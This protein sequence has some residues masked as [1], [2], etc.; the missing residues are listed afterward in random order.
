M[1]VDNLKRR[2]WAEI[3]LDNAK[4]NYNQIKSHIKCKLCCVVKANAYGHGAIKLAKL[5]QSLGADYLAVSNIEEALQLRR[6]QIHT[7]IL[8]L[9]YTPCGCAKILAENDITQCVYSYDY[10]I[11]LSEAASAEKATV[12]IHIKVDTGMGRIGFLSRDE[13][14]DEIKQVLELC[15]QESL[16]IEGIF[17]HFAT[18]DE[19]EDGKEFTHNQ[20]RNFTRAVKLLEERGMKFKIKHCANS[21][22]IFDFPEAHLDMVRAGIVL[23]GLNPSEKVKNAPRL[24]PVMSLHSVISHIKTLTPEQTVSYGRKYISTEA[25]RIATIPIGYAD[26]FWRMNG[27]ERYSI[28]VNGSPAPI[29]GRVCMDQ[30]MV[31]VT[32]IDCKTEDEVLIFAEDPPFTADNIA[33]INDTIN[34]EVVCA[35]GHRVP[36]AFTENG[37]IIAW[38]DGIFNE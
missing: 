36:R 22:G 34:Y 2:C 30:M 14:F 33:S 23:Y 4:F 9:G 17:T 31:D 20:L 24:K 10:G 8:I 25:K 12:K 15:S 32:G 37:K 7:P 35:V 11:K 29:V 19:G 21:A 1:F 38:E 3:N 28:S 6:A 18:A 13:G 26:G 16:D 27:E 5:Y